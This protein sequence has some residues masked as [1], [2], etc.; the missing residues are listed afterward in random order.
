[1]KKECFYNEQTVSMFLKAQ[2]IRFDEISSFL[3]LNKEF[4]VKLNNAVV[5]KVVVS[6]SSF[7]IYS[8]NLNAHRQDLDCNL[9]KQWIMFVKDSL[10]ESEQQMYY[11]ALRQETVEQIHSVNDDYL[12]QKTKLQKQMETLCKSRKKEIEVSC[13]KLNELSQIFNR[14]TKNSVSA[15]NNV[16]QELTK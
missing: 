14:N 10:S 15:N 1:M 8:L 7:E 6:N 13:E 12:K 16:E 3:G 11:E 9:S 2:N 5:K 4:C